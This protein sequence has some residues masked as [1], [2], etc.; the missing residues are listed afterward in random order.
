M[1]CIIDE[2]EVTMFLSSRVTNCWLEVVW[3]FPNYLWLDYLPIDNNDPKI[4][5][6]C[7]KTK[8]MKILL[9]FIFTKLEILKN[10]YFWFVEIISHHYYVFFTLL[11]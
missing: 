1:L 2:K 8:L 6:H 10:H 5:W 4:W 3:A 9:L 7:C 11:F